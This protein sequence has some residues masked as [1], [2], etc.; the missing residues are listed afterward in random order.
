M[1]LSVN[2]V[3][4]VVRNNY[5]IDHIYNEYR[6]IGENM[7]SNALSIISII[8]VIVSIVFV[9]LSVIR[10]S[11]IL[12]FTG[13]I[14]LV[15]S[16]LLYTFFNVYKTFKREK[17]PDFDKLIESGLT[18]TNCIECSSKNVLEDQYCINC[19]EKLYETPDK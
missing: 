18:I 7:K 19:G 15:V 14:L 11:I 3:K 17:S 13:I 6:N 4:T 16:T 8:L 2:I 1:I 9:L 10:D 5:H 12:L